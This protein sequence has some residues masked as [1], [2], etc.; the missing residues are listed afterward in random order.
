MLGY[1]KNEPGEY[2]G[3]EKSLR[4]QQ[5]L[6]RAAAE[7]VISLSKA[8]SLNNQSL[9]QFRKTFVVV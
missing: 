4:F 7:E 1:R 3:T 2:T 6:Y 8:A 5:L 9:S